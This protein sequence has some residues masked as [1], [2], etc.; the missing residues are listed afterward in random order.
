MKFSSILTITAAICSAEAAT[1]LKGFNLG[2]NNPDGSCKSQA[3]WKK[4]FE[5]MLALPGSF[6]NARLFASSDCGTLANAVPAAIATKT[7]LLVG[8]WTQDDNHYE[9]EKAALLSVIKQH[10]HDWMLAVSVGSEDLYRKEVP[11]SAI[12]RKIYDVRGM[13]STV[14]AQSIKVGHVDTWTAWVDGANSEVIKA[15]DFIGTDGY[16]YY[17]DSSIDNAYNVFWESVQTVK[18]VVAR[19]APGKPIWIT[20]SGWPQSGAT[21]GAAVPSKANAQ[22]YW[23]SVACSAFKQANT[24]WFILRDYTANPSFGVLDANYKPIINLKC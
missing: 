14:N 5:T 21:L 3:D 19:V 15:C 2:V 22:Q 10:G 4:D 16:P 6:P 18:D 13:L 23:S 9:A 24:F 20:E 1:Y 17:Q 8:V 7:R 11:A 12:A